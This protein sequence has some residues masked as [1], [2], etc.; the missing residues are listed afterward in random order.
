MAKFLYIF[1]FVTPEA[2]DYNRKHGTYDEFNRGVF[3]EADTE[4][5][6]LEWGR[7]VTEE[8]VKWL[9]KDNRSWKKK[10]FAHWIESKLD[11]CDED[12]LQKLPTIKYGEF[13][14]F[15]RFHSA[16]V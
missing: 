7:E 2:E 10:P 8:Y 1:W 12:Y 4:E 13:P 9:F 6:A 5:K 3:I 15:P 16:G 14:D 11:D